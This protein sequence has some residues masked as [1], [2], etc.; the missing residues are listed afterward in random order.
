[1]T[2]AWL[3]LVALPLAIIALAFVV[4]AATGRARS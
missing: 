3:V 2:S 4:Y 1:M